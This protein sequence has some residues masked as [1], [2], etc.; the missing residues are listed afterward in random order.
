MR[1]LKASCLEACS[2]IACLCICCLYVRILIWLWLPMEEYARASLCHKC[3]EGHCFVQA[4]LWPT[5]DQLLL[6]PLL[7]R[8]A[9]M[10]CTATRC[11]SMLEYHTAVK[12][13]SHSNILSADIPGNDMFSALYTGFCN[14]WTHQPSCTRT[15]S[16][17]IPACCSSP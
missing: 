1:G 8:W 14:H 2:V 9:N 10:S 7:C 4:L 3:C 11:L 16:S 13:N 15:C 5:Y 6:W 12:G 17:S